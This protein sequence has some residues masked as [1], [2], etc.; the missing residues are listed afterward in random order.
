[1]S[2]ADSV[3][4]TPVSKLG[5]ARERLAAFLVAGGIAGA[6]L[7][8][9]EAV[10]LRPWMLFLAWVAYAVTGT[11]AKSG[12]PLLACF[13]GGAIAGCV[14]VVG[15]TAAQGALGMF[16]LPLALALGCGALALLEY[17]PVLNTVSSWFFGMVAFF[18][19]GEPPSVALVTHLAAAAMLGVLCG[20]LAATLRALAAP[21]PNASASQ[22]L[23]RE[24]PP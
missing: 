11:G 2:N 5:M 4:N 7:L 23:K 13:V 18:A 19:T 15:G 21:A 6:A 8:L 24:G 12:L 16:A 17:A 14:V 10:G 22:P 3:G 9:C 20:W 1:M